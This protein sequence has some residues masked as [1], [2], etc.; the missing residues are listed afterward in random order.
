MSDSRPIS[1]RV[2]QLVLQRLAN[3]QRTLEPL[4]NVDLRASVGS[5]EN[6]CGDR[7]E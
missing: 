1:P 3:I 7:D 6:E 4:R 5:L 2:Q